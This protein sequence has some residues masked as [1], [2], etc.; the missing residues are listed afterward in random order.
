MRQQERSLL[1]KDFL[2][3]RELDSCVHSGLEM[4]LENVE[5]GNVGASALYHLDNLYYDVFQKVPFVKKERALFRFTGLKA[6]GEEKGEK[7]IGEKCYAFNDIKNGNLTFGNPKLFNDPMDPLIKA[8]AEWRKIHHD[9]R[10]DKIFYQLINRILGKIRICSLVDPMRNVVRRGKNIKG[11]DKCSP[12]M[13]AHYADN[14]KGICIQ[15]RIKPDN[16][17]DNDNQIVRLFD[18]N[19]DKP[20]PLDGNIPFMDSLCVKGDCWRYEKETRLIMYSRNE[21]GDYY[22]LNGYEIEAV[23]MGCRIEHEKR[24]YLKNL[25][26]GTNIDLYQMSFSTDNI[27]RVIAHQL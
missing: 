5:D 15:C 10:D 21:V 26:K 6:A 1:L 22:S 24:N 19:Y 11:I 9:D 17:I 23:Y 7:W 12:L 18:V 16:L 8:W 27:T 3:S 20:F 2:E 25:L 4:A 14:H 13:W